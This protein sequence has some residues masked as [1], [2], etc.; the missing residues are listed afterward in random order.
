PA[1]LGAGFVACALCGHGVT[2]CRHP[3]PKYACAWHA[4]R[5]SAACAGI[6]YR[7]ESDVDAALLACV[8]PLVDGGIA[9]RAVVRLKERLDA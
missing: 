9:E 4:S 5:G 8:A 3:Y 7:N 6:G 2:V 1:H